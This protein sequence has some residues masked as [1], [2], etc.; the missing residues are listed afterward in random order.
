MAGHSRIARP[1]L[2]PTPS[3]RTTPSCS[4][5]SPAGNAAPSRTIIPISSSL[6]LKIGDTTCVCNRDDRL[7][8]P[9]PHLILIQPHLIQAGYTAWQT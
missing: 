6:R 1:A 9:S 2:A 3:S 4:S 8:P 5:A 7:A